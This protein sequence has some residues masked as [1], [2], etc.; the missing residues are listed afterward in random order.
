MFKNSPPLFSLKGTLEDPDRH[1]SQLPIDCPTKDGVMG[2]LGQASEDATA[3]T[4][5]TFIRQLDFYR[6][7]ADNPGKE[8]LLIDFLRTCLNDIIYFVLHF[9]D[10]PWTENV[11]R[12]VIENDPEFMRQFVKKMSDKPWAE[13]VQKILKEKD[14]H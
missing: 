4:Y 3:E 6:G 13:M 5:L 8:S 10:A 1:K 14:N 9:C 2:V 7:F 11:A 12:L